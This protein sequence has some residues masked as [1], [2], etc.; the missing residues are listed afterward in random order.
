MSPSFFI[1]WDPGFYLLPF[2]SQAKSGG[3]RP[4]GPRYAEGTL[5][6]DYSILMDKIRQ[7]EFVNWLLAQKGKKMDWKH[8][9]TR[10]EAQALEQAGQS[11]GNE[12]TEGQQRSQ[13]KS[14]GLRPR[15]PRY[16]E[17]TLISD[18]SILMDK[19]RQHEFVNWLLAQKGKKMDWKHNLTRREAQALEQAG[20]SEGNEETE[21]QQRSQAKSGSLRPRSPRY[22]EGT[23]ISDYSILMDKIRQHEF[24]NWLLAQKGKKMDWKHNLTRRE[25][26]ALEQTGQ[27]EKNEETE[28]Q[29]RSE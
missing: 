20:Q 2:R 9:L 19:I 26:Q 25:A 7:H 24:V 1:P 4:R 12:E 10:R 11:E 3:L 27:S 28:G 13:A 16:A 5:I 15:G 21:G 17:G 14:G 6:S 22:A 29:E 18:Y 8:N 23:L